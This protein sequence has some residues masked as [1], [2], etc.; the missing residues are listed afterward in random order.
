MLLSPE[1][2][3]EGGISKNVNSSEIAVLT[4]IEASTVNNCLECYI[5]T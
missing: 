3:F 4:N 2:N 1:T 5:L